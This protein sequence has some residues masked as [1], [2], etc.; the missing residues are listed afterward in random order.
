[1]LTTSEVEL[2]LRSLMRTIVHLILLK[3]LFQF[4]HLLEQYHTDP[5]KHVD[6]QTVICQPDGGERC[7]VMA[8]GLVTETIC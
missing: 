1:M 2:V 7:G 4:T 3:H 5:E 6:H 8:Q